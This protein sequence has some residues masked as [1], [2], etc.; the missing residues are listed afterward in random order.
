MPV[1]PRQAA[2]GHRAVDNS[3]ISLTVLK[4]NSSREKEGVGGGVNNS[5]TGIAHTHR[6]IDIIEPRRV[7]VEAHLAVRGADQHIVGSAGDLEVAFSVQFRGGLVVHSLISAKNVVP[8]V[9][10]HVAAEC[11]EIAGPCL[12]QGLQLE[13][14]SG[15]GSGWARGIASWPGSSG[16]SEGSVA[17]LVAMMNVCAPRV[18]E[19]RLSSAMIGKVRR[20]IPRPRLR[21]A[22]AAPVH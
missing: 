6:A 2:I 18:R 17:L 4:Q 11:Q 16:T 5:T 15:A 12:A 21:I 13:R 3:V 19:Q 14:H 22:K 8:I 20:R 9:D 7:H 1:W 10:H